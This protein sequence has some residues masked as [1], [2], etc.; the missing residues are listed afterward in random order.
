M[1]IGV[2]LNRR[3]NLRKN[4]CGREFTLPFRVSWESFCTKIPISSV[5]LTHPLFRLPSNCFKIFVVGQQ[6]DSFSKDPCYQTY[7]PE[8]NPQNPHGRRR[9]PTLVSE[10]HVHAMAYTYPM[11]STPTCA[12]SKYFL[13]FNLLIVRDTFWLYFESIASI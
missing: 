6:K 1:L 4:V 11:H 5:I 10:C 3:L 2:V 7:W 9:E 8:F 13:R 12:I